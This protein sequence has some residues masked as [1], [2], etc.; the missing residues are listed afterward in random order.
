M[1]SFLDSFSNQEHKGTYF[2]AVIICYFLGSSFGYSGLVSTLQSQIHFSS[3]CAVTGSHF[4]LSLLT[5]MASCAFI[6]STLRG[7]LLYQ[8]CLYQIFQIITKFN[9]VFLNLICL[10]SMLLFF[11][12]YVKLHQFLTHQ[13]V[14]SINTS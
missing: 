2:S 14:Y 6:P 3:P 13:Y 1:Q 9:K 7:S 11:P 5:E 8:L 10:S 12:H 4:L